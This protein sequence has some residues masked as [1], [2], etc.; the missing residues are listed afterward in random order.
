MLSLYNFSFLY[1]LFLLS[2]STV[3]LL[4]GS[5]SEATQSMCWTDECSNGNDW[6]FQ[7]C[8]LETGETSCLAQYR[9]HG[10]GEIRS[11]WFGCHAP[12][13]PCS[14]DCVPVEGSASDFSCCCTGDLCNS[15]PGLT[16]TGEEPTASPN[17][18]ST[19]PYAPHDGMHTL[20]VCVCHSMCVCALAC[21]N[22]QNRL[23]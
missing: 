20:C 5:L 2:F 12:D 6:C 4:H 22:S 16:P 18:A 1:S 15:V 3:V 14:P 7:T 23:I 13:R 10:N 8:S 21:A 11:S 9:Q 17:T 19:P